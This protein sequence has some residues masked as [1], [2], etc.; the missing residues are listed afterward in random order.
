M[1]LLKLQLYKRINIKLEDYPDFYY[2][3]EKNKLN[4]NSI[5]K[6][7]SEFLCKRLVPNND[8]YNEEISSH[9]LTVKLCKNNFDLAMVLE[10]LF[11]F[12]MTTKTDDLILFYIKGSNKVLMK[13]KSYTPLISDSSQILPF[14]NIFITEPKFVNQLKDF[15]ENYEDNSL[16]ILCY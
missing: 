11:N 16:I 1:S 6:I 5:I 10:D 4:Y 3:S 14:W 12:H 9:K 8:I 13:L 7:W 15:L 2:I